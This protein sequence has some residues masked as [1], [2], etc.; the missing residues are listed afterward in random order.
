MIATEQP[1]AAESSGSKREPGRIGQEQEQE[2]RQV[3][4]PAAG[5]AR[6]GTRSDMSAAAGGCPSTMHIFNTSNQEQQ[7]QQRQ[8][9][10]HPQQYQH[11]RS[12]LACFN[13]RSECQSKCDKKNILV[14]QHN[15]ASASLSKIQLK[16]QKFL[17]AAAKSATSPSGC[18][19]LT[20]TPLPPA[21]DQP[22]RPP[23]QPLQQ[24]QQQP[25]HSMFES[26]RLAAE[27][28]VVQGACP[29]G[30]QPTQQGRNFPP[31]H[32]RALS[33]HS[34]P[35]FIS[36]A[37]KAVANYKVKAPI[38]TTTTTMQTAS[39]CQLLSKQNDDH[40][41]SNSERE[42]LE[43]EEFE[44]RN[45]V[46]KEE[47]EEEEEVSRRQELEAPIGRVLP[48]R[49]ESREE[50]DRRGSGKCLNSASGPQTSNINNHHQQQQHQQQQQIMAHYKF[51]NDCQSSVLTYEQVKRLDFV[52][53]QTVPIHG[54]GN[55]PTLYVKLKELIRL[56]KH[57]L[58][59]EHSIEIRDVRLFGGA[60]SYVLAPENSHYNDLDLIF[61]TDLSNE[62]HFDVIRDVVL[63]CLREFYPKEQMEVP[64][65]AYVHKM[66]K[67]NDDDRW[68]LISLGVQQSEANCCN[69]AVTL[70]NGDRHDPLRLAKNQGGQQSSSENK[71][72]HTIAGSNTSISNAYHLG[73]RIQCQ[74][75]RQ[76]QKQFPNSIELKFVDRMRRK[77][78]F[79][80]DSFQ[81]ILDSLIQF[82]D[83]APQSTITSQRNLTN[84]H[85]SST[86]INTRPMIN[87]RRCSSCCGVS[88]GYQMANNYSDFEAR[89]NL[90]LQDNRC[91]HHNSDDAGPMD[92]FART[93]AEAINSAPGK[94]C[95]AL[96]NSSRSY[97]QLTIE[98][99][100]SPPLSSEASSSGCSSSSSVVSSSSLSC[101]DDHEDLYCDVD[102]PTSSSASTSSLLS[103]TASSLISSDGQ[104][105][106]DSISHNNHHARVPSKEIT[107]S[108][109]DQNE[110]NS[111]NSS[112][113]VS[114]INLGS[115]ASVDTK[116]ASDW[117]V[118]CVGHLDRKKQLCQAML[119]ERD[120]ETN[121][122]TCAVISENFYPT[123]IGRSEYGDFK[124]ALYHL[125]KKLIA[126]RSPEE[127]R[128]GGL[129][130]YCNL[131]VKNYKPTNVY[132][133][134]TLERYMC[135]RF[136]IDFSDL[137]Q[138]QA[139]LESYLANHFSDDPILKYDYLNILHNVVQRST[140]C[141][142]NH[143]L[144][145]TL[146]MIRDLA[147]K[148]NEQQQQPQFQN[149]HLASQQQV[150]QSS[151]SSVKQHQQP[152]Q[153]YYQQQ[154]PVLIQSGVYRV[155]L[156][157]YTLANSGKA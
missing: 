157:N 79:S 137:N 11:Q 49:D 111:K 78:E 147:Y 76:H 61:G 128:G 112:D 152:Q 103:S 133:I 116:V 16:Q 108:D 139:K 106:K 84:S 85:P 121:T 154:K 145:L 122:R 143:D 127:I 88:S 53:D 37:M 31:Q 58:Q 124:E 120:F 54:R 114:N 87:K 134:R 42:E 20:G 140:V 156:V 39:G 115:G 1:R 40:T 93:A 119:N 71:A 97:F 8:E 135:S 23:T 46:E 63:E 104:L 27:Q 83:Y 30:A 33:Q 75:Q 70:I 149:Q 89:P 26:G 66:V 57:K 48:V 32:Q 10:E 29:A 43:T 82:Y 65:P 101:D 141:L 105:C 5:K 21:P 151:Q 86:M 131:L 6:N 13:S 17:A 18:V 14:S 35:I 107:S 72:L 118:S 98:P 96:M 94:S 9:D 146:N 36:G 69:Q 22:V 7:Q 123:V 130:K 34:R 28:Q 55:F 15:F 80:V 136:F 52:M 150:Q 19:K 62:D 25:H 73:H 117:C 64:C 68:S 51:H 59:K 24:Q 148:I 2:Q 91:N 38:A 45:K 60:A 81:I 4:C 138:Q 102:G 155:K 109:G 3:A 77:F 99:A 132:Q 90:V 41:D 74:N 47:E 95:A 44:V 50:N 56:V 125:E 92:C 126:T 129:L 12:E 142:M 144:R 100:N 67:V 110:S 153:P 113:Q